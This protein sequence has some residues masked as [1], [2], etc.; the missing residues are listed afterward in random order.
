MDALV[1]SYHRCGGGR[2]F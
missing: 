2:S 1:Q